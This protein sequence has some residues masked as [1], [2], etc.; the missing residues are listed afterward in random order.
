MKNMG[1]CLFLF[2]Q[3]CICLMRL[4]HPISLLYVR[5]NSMIVYKLHTMAYIN[6]FGNQIANG[7]CQVLRKI[8]YMI[9]SSR[10]H[11]SLGTIHKC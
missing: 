10:L 3:G 4:V 5:V 8:F 2:A 11:C 9:N 6:M 7:F 1:L